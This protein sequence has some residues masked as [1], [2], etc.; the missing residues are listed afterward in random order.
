M[1]TLTVSTSPLPQRSLSLDGE[2]RDVEL[3]FVDEHSEL[4]FNAQ[5]SVMSVCAK[6]H[7]LHKEASNGTMRN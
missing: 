4:S 3:P 1:L 5:W 7:L 6:C 2:G